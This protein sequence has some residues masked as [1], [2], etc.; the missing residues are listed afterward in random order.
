MSNHCVKS[1]RSSYTG[2]YPQKTEFYACRLRVLWR[3]LLRKFT[4]ALEATHGQID[5][6][7][8]Q[9]PYK[10]LGSRVAKKKKAFEWAPWRFPARKVPVYV[11][12]M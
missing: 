7:V 6:F 4:V 11:C 9:L 10:P 2:L 5:G 3:V 8:G 1:P 12:R